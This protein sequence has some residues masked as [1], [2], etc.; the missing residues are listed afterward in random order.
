M[1]IIVDADKN[2]TKNSTKLTITD[3]SDKFCHLPF[4]SAA[5]SLS[6]RNSQLVG[7]DNKNHFS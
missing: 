5:D 3:H 4:E 1:N 2:S 6:A 7:I